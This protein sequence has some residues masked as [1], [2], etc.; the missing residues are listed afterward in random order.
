LELLDVGTMQSS[1][2]Y[3][4]VLCASTVNSWSC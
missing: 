1:A 4:A 2:W 3:S